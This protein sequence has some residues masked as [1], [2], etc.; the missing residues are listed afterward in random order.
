MDDQLYL[1]IDPGHRGGAA[2][3]DVA[4]RITDAWR[5][6]PGHDPM[7]SYNNLYNYI[8]S[9]YKILSYIEHIRLYPRLPLPVLLNTQNLLLNAGQWQ[10]LL[11]LLR[12]PYTQI[13]PGD[14]QARYGLTHWRKRQ[15]RIITL[16]RGTSLPD[17]TSPL[18]LA[19]H[20]WP[21]AP[22][23]S[24]AD[25]GIAVALLLADLARRD[26]QAPVAAQAPL[27]LT[28][29]SQRRRNSRRRTK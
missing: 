20:L 7:Q 4:G 22:L 27:P 14:W 8:N 2:L 24:Q 15:A 17:L 11:D 5:W 6:R 18:A 10:A 13:T 19:R 23:Q 3:L 1:G 25:D 16:A 12:I 26:H 29:T 28:T 9:G 21:D